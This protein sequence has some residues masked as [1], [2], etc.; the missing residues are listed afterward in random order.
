MAKISNAKGR[1]TGSGYS[2]VFNDEELGYLLSRVQ[3]TV[4]SNGTELEKMI[5]ERSNT[6]D[7]LNYFIDNVE[8]FEHGTYLCTK[9]VVKRSRF[10][11]QHEPDMLIFIVNRRGRL[12]IVELKDGDSFDTKKVA[13]ERQSLISF[14]NE[15]SRHIPFE[16]S[17]HVCSFNQLNKNEI[18]TGFKATFEMDEILTGF[19][20]CEILGINY[21]EI[22]EIRKTDAE[23]NMDYFITELLRIDS[24]RKKILEKKEE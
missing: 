12:M 2:R 16:V 14:M 9:K 17:I 8:D 23:E 21:Y 3:A 11:T 22:L 10:R 4:I 19:E 15:I 18:Y 5:I 7:D 24:V 1:V 20:L 13:G 6:I